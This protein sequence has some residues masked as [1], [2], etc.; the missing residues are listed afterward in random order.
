MKWFG[1]KESPDGL[2]ANCPVVLLVKEAYQNED[3]S[4]AWAAPR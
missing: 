3:T 1:T 4:V 2:T